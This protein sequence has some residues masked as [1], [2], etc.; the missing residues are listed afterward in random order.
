MSES[1]QSLLFPTLSRGDAVRAEAR[2]TVALQNAGIVG[3]DWS[4]D[5]VHGGDSYFA[6][7]APTATFPPLRD[8]ASFTSLR[9]D[10]KF[11]SLRDDATF[12]SLRD[13]ATHWSGFATPR[14][15]VRQATH[16]GVGVRLGCGIN[17]L[18]FNLLSDMTCP[19]CLTE[20]TGRAADDMACGAA[21]D[22]YASGTIPAIECPACREE[23]DARDWVSSNV[24]GFA[25]LA[26]EFW[27]WPDLRLP[28]WTVDIPGLMRAAAGA[29][30]RF[31]GAML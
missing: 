3:T 15:G 29:P 1:F 26:Y 6:A 2:V 13:D 12:P 11:P 20:S 10:A 17:G 22:F 8:D 25:Y 4:P 16:N 7:Y 30:I 31:G 24:P 9:D 28:G 18:E 23:T 27:N 21:A 14:S 19:V 5:R